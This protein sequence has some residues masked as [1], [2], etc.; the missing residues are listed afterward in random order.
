MKKKP[1]EIILAIE[2]VKKCFKVALNTLS[3]LQ[4]KW[5]CEMIGSRAANINRPN[6]TKKKHFSTCFDL[7]LISGSTSLNLPRRELG[8]IG[9][10]TVLY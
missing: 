8:Y 10:W 1:S 5:S 6:W 9:P 7:K 2:K 4:T 3:T